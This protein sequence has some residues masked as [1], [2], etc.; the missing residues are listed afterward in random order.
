[1][2][3]SSRPALPRC[4]ATVRAV[5]GRVAIVI[6]ALNEEDALPHVLA[7]IPAS[8]EA[9]VVVVDNGS[10]DR[11]AEV[12]RAHG[13]TVLHQPER[14]YGAACLAGIEH[15]A[16]DP[17]DVLV[18]LDGDH[19]DDPGLL[20]HL[21]VQPI[22][23]D[24]VD[25]VLSTR[26]QGGAEAGS[27]TPVQIA[28]NHLQVA[29]LRLRFGLKLT[30]MGPMRAIRFSSL[31]SL[32]M[33]DRTWGWNVEMACKAA[34]QGLRIREVPVPYR[35]RIGVSKISGTLSGVVRAGG[36]ILYAFAKYGR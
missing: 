10:T 5:P 32:R 21:F 34:R 33:Q 17:P 14:G 9:T 27:M 20:P 36:K 13:A 12:A 30:D 29:L 15:L 28:G 23:D 7:D 2:N 3:P 25:L 8:L 35:N 6:P 18:I 24:A 26:T 22:L 4:A 11:T 19:A 31:Q 16:A 1:M